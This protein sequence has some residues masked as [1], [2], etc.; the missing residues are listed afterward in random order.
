MTSDFKFDMNLDDN[1]VILS[2]Y[3][4]RFDI[5]KWAES[6]A[7]TA[8]EILK[9]PADWLRPNVVDLR[10]FQTPIILM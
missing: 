2:S 3:N 8:G 1:G 5:A 6:V 4:G 9:D 7:A 10:K